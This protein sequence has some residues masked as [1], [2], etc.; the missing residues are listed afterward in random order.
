MKVS[1]FIQ[2]EVQAAEKQVADLQA[3]RHKERKL[4]SRAVADVK[5]RAPQPFTKKNTRCSD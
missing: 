5:V 4:A 3:L 1:S 2:S